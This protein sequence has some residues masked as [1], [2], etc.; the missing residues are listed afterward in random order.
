MLRIT[1][2]W[3]GDLIKEGIKISDSLKRY[4]KEI[5]NDERYERIHQE[6]SWKLRKNRRLTKERNFFIILEH[7]YELKYFPKNQIRKVKE[8]E[9]IVI[10]VDLFHDIRSVSLFMMT[11]EFRD[12]ERCSDSSNE[13]SLSG[14]RIPFLI[15]RSWKTQKMGKK[16]KEKEKIQVFW[17]KEAVKT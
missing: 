12:N 10:S 9:K 3:H 5:G 4:C 17:L 13:E 15:A 1:E 11:Q 2:H 6:Q 16:V 8:E 14:S 7:D